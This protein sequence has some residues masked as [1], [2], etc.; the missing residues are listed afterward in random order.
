MS[1]RIGLRL[2]LFLQHEDEYDEEK[3]QKN[4]FERGFISAK[5][6]DVFFLVCWYGRQCDQMA[7]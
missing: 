7:V 1:E 6:I 5:N 4:I 2:I 3:Q